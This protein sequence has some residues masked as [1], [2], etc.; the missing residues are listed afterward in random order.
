M[1]EFLSIILSLHCFIGCAIGLPK[2][3][4]ILLCAI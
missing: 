2:V 3:I 4:L 1:L